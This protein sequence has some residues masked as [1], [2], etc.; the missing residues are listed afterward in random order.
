MKNN[1]EKSRRGH[2]G[3]SRDLK[4]CQAQIYPNNN[5]SLNKK[6]VFCRFDGRPV[7]YVEDGI[8]KKKVQA[9]KHM[10]RIPRGW[11]WDKDILEE[12]LAEGIAI[13]EI[14]DTE[15][16]VA[17]FARIKDILELGREINR[18]FGLQVVLP[19]SYWKKNQINRDFHIILFS[20]TSK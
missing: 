6:Q 3:S 18:G 10:L 15:E 1:K 2:Y 16:D 12:A 13:T 9:S 19:I 7:G 11:A 8:L 17:Y 4:H 5:H 14:F 20:L